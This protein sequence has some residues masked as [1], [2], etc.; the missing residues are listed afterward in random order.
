MRKRR[1]P[2]WKVSAWSRLLLSTTLLFFTPSA[3]LTS[4]GIEGV[5]VDGKEQPLANI[6]L[7]AKPVEG[8]RDAE[9]F[10]T[11]TAGNGT[12][13]FKY[14]A[15]ST[16]YLLIPR[17]EQ[18]KTDT[19][20]LVTSGG[21][22]GDAHIEYP[23]VIRFTAKDG[24]ITDSRTGLEWLPDSGNAFTWTGANKFTQTLSSYRGQCGW[25][26]PTDDELMNI[27]SFRDLRKQIKI[28]SLF[29]LRSPFVWSSSMI[30]Y[31]KS[32]EDYYKVMSDMSLE[33]T[34]LGGVF[35]LSVDKP[36]EYLNQVRAMGLKFS[37]LAKYFDFS[38]GGDKWTKEDEAGKDVRT[39]M[40]RTPCEANQ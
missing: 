3:C 29:H 11:F 24:V 17:D 14:L 6:R 36:A 37:P 9:Q 32:P 31:E 1:G 23:L 20:F 39:L 18:W 15:V 5:V 33:S 7:I 10:E 12:F 19:Q 16:D 4:S 27:Y 13:K 28:D 30:A 26:L 2:D 22:W 8:A 40:V 38:T 25:R 21:I 34:A 35:E